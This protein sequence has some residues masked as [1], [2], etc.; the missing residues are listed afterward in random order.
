MLFKN[1]PHLSFEFKC[2]ESLIEKI[3][4]S[5]S[6]FFSYKL[7]GSKNLKSLIEDFLNDYSKG[8]IEKLPPLLWPTL[9][10]FSRKVLEITQTIP[11][12]TKLSYK[13][14]AVLMENSK[15]CR[16]IG[17]SLNKNPFPLVIPCHRVILTNGELGGYA[18]GKTIKKKLLQFEEAFS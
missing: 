13:E 10:V 14:I 16:A 6:S 1:L 5:D 2:S 4:I 17:N 8:T 9:P 3:T 18:F 12:G 11:L 15:A 7:K